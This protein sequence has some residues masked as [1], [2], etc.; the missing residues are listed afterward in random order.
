MSS[1]RKFWIILSLLMA[2]SLVLSACQP[3]AT[4]EAPVVDE[5]EEVEEEMEEKPEP[6]SVEVWFH[7]GKG[8][9][10]DVLD[11]QVSDFNAMQDDIF[12]DAVQLPEGSYNDQVNAAALAGDLP[13][14]LDFDGP[15]LYN[16]AWSGYLQ[17]ID[18]FVSTDL[19]NDFL[20]SI[21]NQGTYAGNL[22]SLGTFD[23]GL[24]IWG[25]KT[26]L[27][28]A[29]VRIPTSIED[30]WSKE[31]FIDALEK[32][33]ALDEV[34]YAIDFKMNYGAGEWF[35][36]GFAPLMQSFGGDLI[37]RSTYQTADGFLNSPESVEGLEFFQSLFE[38]GYANPE[39]AGD[40]DFYINKTTALSWVGHWMWGPHSENL[41]DEVV[42][43]PMPILGEKAVT[44]MGSWNWGITS[45]CANPD[46]AWKF[47]SYI[48]EPEQILRMTDANGA[49]PARKSAIANS[50]LFGEGGPLNIFVQQLEGGVAFERPVTPAYPVITS[51]FSDVI[52]NIVAGADVK[53]ELD[54]AVKTIG[55]DIQDNQGY[56]APGS[57]VVEPVTVEVWF[58][59]GKGEERDVLDA[60]V[61]D[62]NAKQYGIVIDAVQ[63]PEGS[64]N[65]QVNAAALADDLPCLLDFDGPFLYNYAWSGYLQ[66]LDDFVSPDLKN[67]FLPS[68][69]N[70][71][72]YAGNLYSLGTFDSGLAIWGNKTYL[73]AAGVRIPTSIDDAWSKEEFVDALEKL[74]ALDEVEYAIDFKMNYGAGEWFSYG[75]APILQSFG[76]DLINRETY[77]SAD[78]VLNSPE[79]VEGLEFFQSLFEDGYANPE[80]AGDDDF[81]IKKNTALSWVGHWMWTPHSDGLGDDLVLIPMP[82][83]GE[84]AVT[85]MGSWNWGLTSTC[86]N[87]DE[88]WEFL[89]Y[90][91][92]PAEIIHMINANG[93]VP[94]RKSAIA[95]SEL[96]GEGGALNLFVQQLEGGVALE[97]PVTP[98]YPVITSAF[99]DVIQ[100]IVAGADVKE[101]LDKAVEAID[102]DIEDNQGYPM[103]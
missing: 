6:V 32:L 63:L 13:C 8:E 59:S 88:A 21:I 52:Q 83:L 50:D 37:D 80:P 84:K 31:E 43:I 97:R 95:Q 81:Y 56:P 72:T 35:S 7:S 44:G 75:F 73:E 47:L 40:E 53:E 103:P 38:D 82:V 3:A 17:P 55:Q 33:Q 79:S 89:H 36:Y 18:Q 54:K 2:F 46:G 49:V 92:S 48:T 10:R 24:A 66:P 1:K 65:D 15:F 16:Y 51:S 9:E 19:K 64:Y 100:N 58:H 60:Q 91:V 25:N 76:G 20:P 71:G 94:A 61:A 67:D 28:E 12:I 78:G 45:T 85:G 26:Y 29:G 39:P 14:L 102:L 34:E 98:A 57:Q 4:E 27:D 23:S 74:Q 30:A 77:M 101:E 99:S 70:Q 90:L 5:V 11:A 68:I 96:Y 41:G 86:E 93:A 69:I 62:F 22:Y 42:L 87:S